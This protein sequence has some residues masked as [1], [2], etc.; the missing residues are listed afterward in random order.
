MLAKRLI[1]VLV[2]ALLVPMVLVACGDDEKAS[3]KDIDAADAYQQ[4]QKNQDAILVDVRTQPEWVNT[5]IPAGAQTRTWDEASQT[6]DTT[7][8]P[9]DAEIY[10]ICN[11]GRRSQDAARKLIDLGYKK[12]YSINGGIQRWFSLYPSTPYQS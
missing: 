12:V 8:L 3:F 10:L 4:L 6:M 11:S 2:L 5:G 9:K 7:D 1:L